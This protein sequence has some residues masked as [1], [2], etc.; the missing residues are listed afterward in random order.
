MPRHVVAPCSSCAPQKEIRHRIEVSRI[1]TTALLLSA[2]A[3]SHQAPGTR[4]DD[5]DSGLA[6]P[7][8][9]RCDARDAVILDDVELRDG[10]EG[11]LIV[12]PHLRSSFRPA[13]RSLRVRS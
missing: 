8:T 9:P 1:A 2:C 7:W 5:P 6:A 12:G 10:V 11:V 3:T 13:T 4:P